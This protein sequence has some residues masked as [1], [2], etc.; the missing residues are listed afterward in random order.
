MTSGRLRLNALA[1]LRD[2]LRVFEPRTMLHVAKSSIQ[3]SKSKTRFYSALSS[4]SESDS[5]SE[6]ASSDYRS[7]VLIVAMFPIS[8]MSEQS[9]AVAVHCSIPTKLFRF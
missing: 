3:K 1:L 2:I 9:A 8:L 7:F 5:E 4:E 6:P